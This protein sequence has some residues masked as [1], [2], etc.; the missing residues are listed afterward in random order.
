MICDPIRSQGQDAFPQQGIFF[1][2]GDL[3]TAD[4]AKRND[5]ICISELLH[6]DAVREESVFHDDQVFVREEVQRLRIHF[7]PEQV[8]D[9][10]QSGSFAVY[11]RAFLDSSDRDSGR[12]QLYVVKHVVQERGLRDRLCYR[13]HG[14]VV[15]MSCGTLIPK[16]LDRQIHEFPDQVPGYRVV[17]EGYGAAFGKDGTAAFEQVLVDPDTQEFLRSDQMLF[18]FAA[19]AFQDAELILIQGDYKIVK[20]H[21]GGRVPAIDLPRDLDLQDRVVIGCE[22]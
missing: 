14:C 15:Y 6:A 5:R 10:V 1:G 19:F 3:Y 11:I 17:P 22:T 9:T 18:D 21:A 7:L 8:R 13:K 16:L 2:S 12:F 4:A 20:I